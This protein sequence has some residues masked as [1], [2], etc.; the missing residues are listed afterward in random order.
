[1]G[2]MVLSIVIGFSVSL[3]VTLTGVKWWISIGSRIGFK[4]RDMNKPGE[5]YVVDAGGVWVG[6]GAS[7]GILAIIAF[8]RYIYNEDFHLA[9]YMALSLLLFMASFLGFLDD[10]LGWKKGLRVWQRIVFMAPLAL[11]LVVI[12]A[13][14]TTMAIPFIGRVDLGLLYPLVLVP[15][16]VLGASNAY[17][18]I[19]GYNGLEALQGII[20]FFFTAI[21][22]FAKGI[23]VALMASL[24]MLAA[25]L[26]FLYYNWY[27]AKVFPG[28]SMTYG[29]GAY[30]A[31]TV[32][33]G[34]FEKF[35][36]LLFTLYFIELLLFLR[37]LK[38]HVYK[39]NFGK[40]RPD[41]TLDEPYE[42]TYSLTH[43]AIK[44]QKKIRGKATEKG[45]VVT[46]V[47]LQ[48]IVGVLALLFAPV[49]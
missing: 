23:V 35:G 29:V 13:G 11:P 16:G 48:V 8:H 30:Y 12:K 49:V 27:P 39:E 45:V 4:S 6:V 17:N 1:M 28:N 47:L 31:S 42:K 37:G 22:A 38:N 34:N 41:G 24:V 25:L 18:M 21:Y 40:P 5:V 19:A 26:A 32:I 7:F 15:I 20:L 9:D 43:L 10:I 2:P 36:I 44:I 33:L 3:L 46:I 14:V